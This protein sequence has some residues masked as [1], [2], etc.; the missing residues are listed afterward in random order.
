MSRRFRGPHRPIPP[1]YREPTEWERWEAIQEQ[2]LADAMAAYLTGPPPA[3]RLRR[4]FL[5]RRLLWGLWQLVAMA[6]AVVA[7]LW[8]VFGTLPV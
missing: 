7:T 4:P 1:L 5:L 2:M 6:A 3:R 8:L